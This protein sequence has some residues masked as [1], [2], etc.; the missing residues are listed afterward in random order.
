MEEIDLEDPSFDQRVEDE[1]Q[2]Q[3]EE[4]D[5]IE[6]D[7][8]ECAEIP[9]DTEDGD[10]VDPDEIPLG[11]DPMRELDERVWEPGASCGFYVSR[12]TP[13]QR[14]AKVLIINLVTNLTRFVPKQDMKRLLSVLP[15]RKSHGTCIKTKLAASLLGL[16]QSS[17]DRAMGESGN[18]PRTC[19]EK[20]SGKSEEAVP[21]PD[22]DPLPD[23]DRD[24]DLVYDRALDNL[25]DICLANAA[26][27]RSFLAFERD[28]AAGLNFRLRG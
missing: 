16:S 10:C 2:L 22:P 8:S 4:G 25:V 18:L 28:A 11:P 27:G 24:R 20:E 15:A 14:Q 1:I 9:L 13:L 5:E 23:G 3:E 6:L 26:E 19:P 21:D 7:M 17:V 12:H